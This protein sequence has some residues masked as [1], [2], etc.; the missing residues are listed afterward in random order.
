M[1][2]S[3]RDFGLKTAEG[4]IKERRCEMERTDSAG[5]FGGGGSLG[6]VKSRLLF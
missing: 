4:Q 5:F 1:F 2:C 6:P 3:V